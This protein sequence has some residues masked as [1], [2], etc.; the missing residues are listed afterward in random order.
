MRDHARARE[1]DVWLQRVIQIQAIANIVQSLIDTALKEL[2]AQPPALAPPAPGTATRIP[3]LLGRLRV[4]L[5]SLEAV[6]GPDLPSTKEL[7]GMRADFPLTLLGP[8]HAALAELD[9]VFGN[10]PSLRHH[11]FK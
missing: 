5:R 9:Q 1:A 6:A 8:C 3:M 4:S 11:E 7:L 10:A 2:A